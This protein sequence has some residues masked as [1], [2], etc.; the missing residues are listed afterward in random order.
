M[1]RWASRI[2]VCV[3]A[4]FSIFSEVATELTSIV[5]QSPIKADTD[6][7]EDEDAD[8]DEDEEGWLVARLALPRPGYAAHS[9][10]RG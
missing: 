1:A 10:T 5:C 3:L 4:P 6:R 7:E 2:F 8:E 9:D